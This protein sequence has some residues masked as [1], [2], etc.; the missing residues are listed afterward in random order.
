M[1]SRDQVRIRTQWQQCRGWVN[2]ILLDQREL[3]FE[4]VLLRVMW[5]VCVT[6]LKTVSSMC[7]SQ[8][9]QSKAAR[10]KSCS[11]RNTS[12]LSRYVWRGLYS[13]NWMFCLRYSKSPP[14]SPTAFLLITLICPFTALKT[15]EIRDLNFANTCLCTGRRRSATIS[16]CHLAAMS[17]K[18]IAAGWGK[19]GEPSPCL[20]PQ[21]Q[22]YD[23]CQHTPSHTP[24]FPPRRHY[25]STTTRRMST[26]TAPAICP[27]PRGCPCCPLPAPLA[28]LLISTSAPRSS[29][30]MIFPR[31]SRAPVGL[32]VTKMK[33]RNPATVTRTSC[34]L[35]STAGAWDSWQCSF[36]R[37]A[38]VLPDP[39]L[40]GP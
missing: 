35:P 4:M 37:R 20:S 34:L 16:G 27:T 14:K 17:S 18:R 31:T 22:G 39:S 15:K 7:V 12:K 24:Q 32:W 23:T 33:L 11:A 9:A 5:A 26:P 21:Y 13:L 25:S 2:G 30:V 28:P 19:T 36:I 6:R 29:T 1:A 38:V 8:G 3:V 40:W 10:V